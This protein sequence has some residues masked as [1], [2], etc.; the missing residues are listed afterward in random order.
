MLPALF[1]AERERWDRRILKALLMMSIP[2]YFVALFLGRELGFSRYFE[3]PLTAASILYLLVA[4][5]RLVLIWRESTRSRVPV[6]LY[7]TSADF[8]LELAARVSQAKRRVWTTYLRPVPFNSLG[9][10]AENYFRVCAQWAARDPNN[11]AF[12]RIVIQPRCIEMQNMLHIETDRSDSLNYTVRVTENNIGDAISMAIV[13]DEFVFVTFLAERDEFKG[14]SCHSRELVAL[15]Q[16]YH[17]QLWQNSVDVRDYLRSLQITGS[18][19][20]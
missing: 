5:D 8:Y 10:D 11:H 15:F 9:P 1:G 4:V 2:A 20:R 12:R 16:S 6:R 18:A 17:I 19:D 13:D 3:A 7:E 14:F